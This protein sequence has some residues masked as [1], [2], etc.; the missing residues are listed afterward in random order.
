MTKQDITVRLQLTACKCH[1]LTNTF[2]NDLKYGRKCADNEWKDIIIL[3]A[4]IKL[5]ENYDLAAI[6]N[7][8]T[9]DQLNIMLDKISKLTKICFKPKNFSYSS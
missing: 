5:L 2:V 9:K 7:C 4:Y 1:E 8:I 6:D 3:N